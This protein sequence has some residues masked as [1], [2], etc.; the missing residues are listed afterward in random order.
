MFAHFDQ[1]DI[2]SEYVVSYIHQLRTVA[3]SV[4]FV[5][6]SNLSNTEKKKVSSYC[7]KIITREN[8]GYDFMSWKVGLEELTLNEF[9]EVVICNDSVFGPFNDISE[10]FNI[11]QNDRIDFWGLTSSFEVVEHLQSYF[12][13]FRKNALNS[14]VFSEFWKT[15]KN[16]KTKW[17]YVINYEI[18]LTQKLK[19]DNLTYK[20]VAPYSKIWGLKAQIKRLFYSTNN[21]LRFKDWLFQLPEKLILNPTHYCW[22]EIIFAGVPFL[23]VDLLRN[24][25]TDLPAERWRS[26]LAKKYPSYSI[27]LIDDHITRFKSIERSS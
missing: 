4:I 2:I 10:V 19:S 23:K 25:P 14:P 8:T 27:R 5:S 17:D 21:N 16:E 24:N 22:K 15:I 11:F 3:E 26:L 1:D 7:T 20:A 9:D 18:G 6:T 12:I 13:A